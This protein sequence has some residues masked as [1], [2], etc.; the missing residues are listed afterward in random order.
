MNESELLSQLRDLRFLQDIEDEYLEKIAA[1][2]RRVRFPAGKVIFHEGEPV[3]Q[4]YLIVRGSVSLEF[5]ASGVGC[6]RVMSVADGDLL[7]ISPLL[8]QSRM[9][10]TARAITETE[11]IVLNA[12]QL[13]TLCEHNP[14]FGFE[15]MRRAALALA[16]RL[17]ATRMQLVNVYCT[18]SPT[19][20]AQDEK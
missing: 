12:G 13:L 11:A 16:K 8:E 7:G 5:C 3:A 19:V 20:I 18:Q 2:A 6:T 1:V 4:V 10:A 17:N 9:A 14:R 15:F